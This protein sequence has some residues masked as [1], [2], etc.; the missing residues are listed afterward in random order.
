MSEINTL[1]ECRERA[2]ELLMSAE[3]VTVLRTLPGGVRA[4]ILGTARAIWERDGLRVLGVAATPPR[5]A[6]FENWIGVR[7]FDL[8]LL[9]DKLQ[10]GIAVL[11]DET[12]VLLDEHGAHADQVARLLDHVNRGGARLVRVEDA[13]V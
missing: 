10:H 12:V 2:V 1:V 8:S 7:G 13:H 6:D 5:V 4:W 9:L 11:D 3:R